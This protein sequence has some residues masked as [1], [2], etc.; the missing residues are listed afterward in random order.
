ME[1]ENIS[2]RDTGLSSELR[3]HVVNPNAAVTGLWPHPIHVSH[4]HG[5]ARCPC[6]VHVKLIW[7]YV[8]HKTGEKNG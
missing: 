1:L 4:L 8:M 7:T 5:D 2:P 6:C 3:L